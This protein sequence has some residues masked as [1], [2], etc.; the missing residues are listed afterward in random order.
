MDTRAKK[1][2]YRAFLARRT[3]RIFPLYYLVLLVA[4]VVLP[5]VPLPDGLDAGRE[6]QLYLWLYVSN[7]VEPYGKSVALFPHFWSLAV[8]EQFYLVWPFVVRG[9]GTKRL[10]QV[11]V[12]LV[13]AAFVLR[14]AVRAETGN[15]EAAYT[16]TICR[17][18]A[19]A[20]GA[21]AA[22]AMRTPSVIR[23]LEA[24]RRWLAP[25][26]IGGLAA[27]FVATEGFPRTTFL[28][29][30]IGYTASAACF[31]VGIVSL[32]LRQAGAGETAGAPRRSIWELSPARAIGKYSYGIYVFH[33]P[34]HLLVGKP[35]LAAHALAASSLAV[36]LAYPLVMGAA[37]FV[38]AF[39]SYHVIEAPFLRLKRRFVAT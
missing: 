37:A 27:L 28:D 19:L 39:V 32:V 18:D 13:V 14:I 3:L 20:L 25:A 26:S 30:S 34:L 33:L 5:H 6:H 23:W 1:S 9:L 10:A 22:V 21:L 2:G 7:W 29:Q 24:R 36:G 17:M 15:V 12:F 8:E 35:W 4:F 38:V 16:W 11:S 31:A